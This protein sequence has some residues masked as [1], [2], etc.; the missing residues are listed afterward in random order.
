MLDRI[1]P[2]M[3]ASNHKVLIFCQMTTLMTI[4]EDFLGNRV[5]LKKITLMLKVILKLNM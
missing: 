5:G 2:K 1:L 3:K 4:L